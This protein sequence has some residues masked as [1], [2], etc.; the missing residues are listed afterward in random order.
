VVKYNKYFD[1]TLQTILIKEAVMKNLFAGLGTAL[2]TPFNP[3]GSVN[4]KAM[5]RLIQRQI[6]SNVDFLVPCG[7]TGESPTLATDEHIEVIKFVSGVSAGRIRILAGTGSNST[8]EAIYLTKRAKVVGTHGVL[9]VAPYY[10]KPTPAGQKDY[11]RR[12]A[13]EN[14]LPIVVYDI[15]GRTGIQMSTET[16][17]ELAE[18]GTVCGLK[19]ASGDFNQ[20]MDVIRFRPDGFTVL[21]GDDN[22]TLPLMAL[23]GDGVISVLSNVLP[24]EMKQFISS[25]QEDEPEIAL[26][27]HYRLLPMMKAMFI[28]TNPIPAKTSLSILF[29]EIFGEKPIFRSPMCEMSEENRK[30]LETVLSGFMEANKMQ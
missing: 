29:P 7:T 8:N 18:E 3:D 19:W 17:L 5:A 14:E 25:A 10:N 13:G 4:Y 15:P 1:G 9:V 6:S 12:I 20:L 28:E 24:A 16:I 2:V 30:K 11:F 26:D 22:L 23:G 21:S 27:W